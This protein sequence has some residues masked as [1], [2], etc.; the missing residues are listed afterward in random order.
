MSFGKKVAMYIGLLLVAYVVI[1][2]LAANPQQAATTANSGAQTVAGS[3]NNFVTFL[4]SL[5]GPALLLLVVIVVAIVLARK[6]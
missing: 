6:K 4:T 2:W 3:A 5:S 1:R